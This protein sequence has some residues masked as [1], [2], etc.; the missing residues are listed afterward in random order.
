LIIN[1]TS[2]VE[3]FSA[4]TPAL[5]ET[6]SWENVCEHCANHPLGDM[7]EAAEFTYD[8]PLIQTG[9]DYKDYA[10]QSFPSDCPVL[11]ATADLTHRIFK[12][13]KFDPEATTVATP[14]QEVFRKRR[15]VCQD[16][17]HFEIACLRSLG[18]PA[19]YI[20]G[21]LETDPPPGKPRLIGAD[22]SHAWISV[23]CPGFGWV[24]FDPTNNVIPT[25]RHI[26][27][28]WGRDYSDACPIRGVILGGGRSQLS[29]AVDVLRTDTP[30]EETAA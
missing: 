13:F 24:D 20:S 12:D 27:V 10:A 15:G 2:A 28:A 21:Y 30:T 7:L 5:E 26:T 11:A 23:Y 29:V 16:F 19:R 17:A 3:L 9:P 14:L 4:P 22:A 25:T 1:S 8:S 6:T 18:L